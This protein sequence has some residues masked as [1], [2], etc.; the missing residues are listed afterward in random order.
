[1][2]FNE[3]ISK[4]TMIDVLQKDTTI[5]AYTRINFLVDELKKKDLDQDKKQ[6]YL[7]LLIHIVG[8]IHQPL[9]VARNS[10][11]GG[12]SVKLTWFNEPSNLHRVWDSELIEFQQLS[13][14]EYT[15]SINFVSTEQKKTWQSEPI[16]D[17][18]FDSYTISEKL[19]NELKEPAQKL[20]YEY[21]F[22]HIK[23]LND[24]L[25]KGG[26]HLAGLLNGIYNP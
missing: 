19:H 17:W 3:N 9:H 15:N 16:T 1:V 11:G 4:S 21:N 13:Y 8:D 23:T 2:D 12:N 6:M 14:T 7:R 5:N 24:Q 22:K 25:L 10:T 26:V 18:L 20:S